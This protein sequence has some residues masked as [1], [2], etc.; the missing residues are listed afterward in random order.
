MQLK[1]QEQ[2]N[3]SDLINRTAHCPKALFSAINSVLNPAI[4]PPSDST[5]LTC[6]GFL[7]FFVSSCTFDSFDHVSLPVRTDLVKHMKSSSTPFQSI[8]LSKGCVPSCFKHAVVSP[9]IKKNS[10]EVTELNN[11]HFH[12]H[13]HLISNLPFLSKVLEKVVLTQITPFC[14]RMISWTNSNLVSEL[15]IVQ[16]PLW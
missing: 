12:L 9:L 11:F 5:S 4:A 1:R 7:N 8:S 15:V 16:R 10:L 2:N 14:G 3:F 13:F 6:E